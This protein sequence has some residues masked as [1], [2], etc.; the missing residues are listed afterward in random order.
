[1]VIL[2]KGCNPYNFEPHNSLKLSFKNIGGLCSNFVECESFLESNSPDILALCETHLDDS[3]DSGNL[4]VR[5]YLF[6]NSKRCHYSYA[7]SCSLCERRTWLP[8]AQD[9][10]L[11]NSADSY[12]RFELALFYWVCYFFFLYQSSSSLCTVSASSIS[13]NIDHSYADN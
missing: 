7:W 11:E 5:G 6:F 12:L 2:S 13:S 3:S 9:L 1:M 10:Y 8:F 4:S